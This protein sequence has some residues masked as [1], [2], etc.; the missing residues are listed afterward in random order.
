[1]PA[2]IDEWLPRRCLDRCVS[3]AGDDGS[4]P[5]G[6]CRDGHLLPPATTKLGIR[7]RTPYIFF[8]DTYW[9]NLESQFAKLAKE[10]RMPS[11][12]NEYLLFSGDPEEIIEFYRK[13]LQIL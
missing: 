8:H 10:G 7:P 13:T 1:M 11:W 12:M 5:A 3:H 6:A 4:L 2:A 9:D